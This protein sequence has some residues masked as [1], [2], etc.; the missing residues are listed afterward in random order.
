M[1]KVK[2]RGK[3]AGRALTKKAE[4]LSGDV[5]FIAGKEV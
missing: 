1:I 5:I 4:D 2:P 3:G